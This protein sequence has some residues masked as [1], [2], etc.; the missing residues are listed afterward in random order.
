M[1]EL[2][3][4]DRDGVINQDSPNYVRTP[5]DWQPIEGSLSAIAKL[6]QANYKVVVA[7]N[8][9]GIARG[10]LTL[11]DLDAIHTKMTQAIKDVGGHLDDIFVCPH[12]PDENCSCRKPRP[13]LLLNIAKKFSI[14]TKNMIVIGDSMRDLLAAKSAESMAILVK[15]GN[16]SETLTYIKDNHFLEN[17]A[18]YNDLASAAEA[19]ISNRHI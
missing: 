6:N 12:G 2:I 19:L 4:L 10:Y 17:I 16:G 9:S 8:Q 7:T 18:I 14:P 5:Q 1:I 13:G 3:V 11:N 15:T